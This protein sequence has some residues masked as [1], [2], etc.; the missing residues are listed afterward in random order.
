MDTKNFLNDEINKFHDVRP[1]VNKTEKSS[2]Q[3]PSTPIKEKIEISIFYSFNTKKVE[4]EQNPKKNVKIDL[5]NFISEIY[6]HADK[7]KMKV[8]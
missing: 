5:K 7:D 6:I 1:I 4:L 3:G 2:T 8:T